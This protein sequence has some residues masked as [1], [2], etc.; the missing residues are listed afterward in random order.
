MMS[1]TLFLIAPFFNSLSP[2]LESY[3][4][5]REHAA[6]IPNDHPN[7]HAADEGSADLADDSMVDD[8]PAVTLD[9]AHPN[10]LLVFSAVSPDGVNDRMDGD[11]EVLGRICLSPLP[12]F[13]KDAKFHMLTA[14]TCF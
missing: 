4:R 14:R 3:C 5:C 10:P 9:F 2:S 6:W 1:L 13:E 11:H 12:L 8:S 7:N